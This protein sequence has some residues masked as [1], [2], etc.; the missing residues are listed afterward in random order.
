[1][2]KVALIRIVVCWLAICAS[3]QAQQYVFRAYRQAEGLK[4]LAVNSMATDPSGFL[5]LGTEN[6]VYRFLG[7]SFERFG[8]EQGIAELNIRALVLDPNGVVWVGTNENLYRF[9][10]RRFIAASPQPIQV[11]AL[12]R[13]A[14]EDASHLLIVEKR[15]LYRLQHDKD[16]RVLS[17]LPVF[18]D[19]V[20]SSNPD[21]SHIY[22]VSV[23]SDTSRRLSIWIGSGK[24]LYRWSEEPNATALGID[25]SLTSWGVKE[26]LEE[27]AWE[28]VLLDHSGNLW[29]G[30]RYHV[31]VLAPGAARFE[32]REI[33][34]ASPGDNYP[35]APFVEDREGR[36]LTP[37][38]D[39]M[40]RWDGSGWRIIGRS[41]GLQLTG[42]VV[43]M[44]F[45][46][47]GDLWLATR[48]DGLYN[49][50]GYEDW[51]GWNDTQHLPSAM[52]WALAAAG[53][54]RILMG[55][56]K[57]PGWIDARSGKSGPLFNMRRW[58]LGQVDALGMNHDGS[59]WAG[60]FY[61]EVL[62][63]DA[64]TGKTQQ[65]AKLPTFITRTI[66]DSQGRQFFTTNDGIFERSS[67]DSRAEPQRVKAADVFLT[68]SPQVDAG[69][70][71]PDGTLWFLANKRLLR[72]KNG[73]WTQ[74]AID[75]M[76]KLSGT[77]LDMSCA[78]D[79]SIWVTGQQTGTWRLSAGGNRLDAWQLELPSEMQM[80]TPVAILAD[81]RGWVWLGTDSG[82][83]VWNG[84]GW[85]HLTQ[86]SGLI[87]NDVNQGVLL[88]GG[89]GSIWIGTSGGVAHLLHPERM[90]DS[91]PLTV[92]L[93]EIFRGSTNYFGA[94]QLTFPWAGP[95]LRFHISSP[96]TRNR[97]ELVLK[98]KVDGL[99]PSWVE[100]Q[101]FAIFPSLEPG[102]YTFMAMA[103]N[104]GLNAC[105][106]PVKVDVRILPPW[107]KTSW[108][109]A[110]CCLGSVL[111]LMGIIMLFVGRTRQRSRELEMLV[112]ERTRELEFS[113]EQLR[114][115]ATHDGLTGM[116]NR[117]GVLKALSAELDRARREDTKVIVVLVD[118]DHF[119]RLNDAYGHLAGDEALR[120]FA[121]AVGT[122]LRSYDHAGRY[123][124]EEF[125]LVLTEIPVEAVQQRLTSLHAAIS[126]LKVSIQGVFI[127]LN[128]SLGAT[129]FD[130]S[131]GSVSGESLLSIADEALYEA[132]AAGRNRLVFKETA[133]SETGGEAELQAWGPG[134]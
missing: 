34:G 84:I 116:L 121:A 85:R 73:E 52:T 109:Y 6:G 104:P 75:G 68:E 63:I 130:P 61:A 51:E 38:E 59:L 1:V 82:L 66:A 44:S 28:G 36:V 134:K 21:L 78:L 87:W 83:L 31:A 95:P 41:N 22:A 72:L 112:R 55:T 111:M 57:G 54:N 126:N 127:T 25:G 11:T 79:G 33:P 17:Y 123:G 47:S 23:V 107:W 124:G 70:E 106:V 90:F 46:A 132:K 43:S 100:T 40:A 19:R 131:M 14:V 102:Q 60:T 117:V 58:T 24:G 110:L 122:A 89:D 65:I 71:A 9:D 129:L 16:G 30:G 125:L 105:S 32:A 56:D 67:E 7:S 42:R 29:A 98:L 20:V 12:N 45:D 2:R 35:H 91:I 86:E 39:G 69:C 5:W 80:L 101:D 37:C 120:R 4:N 76:P 93:T 81:K 10:G 108:F 96:T 115:Q 50:T 48:G 49:W 26:G 13:L 103:C 62:R 64:K 18:S 88:A 3:L 53:D 119:K 27:D 118:L 77:M 99:Q 8:P 92:S 94:H 133:V 97:S 113:R 128:C 15:H 74:P 114:I